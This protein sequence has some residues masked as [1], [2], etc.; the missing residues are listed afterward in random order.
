MSYTQ[1]EKDEIQ[2]ALCGLWD[3]LD[4]TGKVMQIS[5]QRGYLMAFQAAGMSAG[6]VVT[7]C[8][9]AMA[10]SKWF[11]MPVELIELTRGSAE[12]RGEVAWGKVI[13]MMDKHGAQYGVE[14]DDPAIS[15]SIRNMGGWLQICGRPKSADNWTRKEFIS[16][17]ESFAGCV[18]SHVRLS[19]HSSTVISQ[20]G[21]SRIEQEERPRGLQDTAGKMIEHYDTGSDVPD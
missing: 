3:T 15:H 5:K 11:P 12:H 16:A 20:G 19:G 14:F 17:Y 7:A 1:Q 10:A 2:I 6:E 13:T 9:K 21:G 8:G 18:T 4:K